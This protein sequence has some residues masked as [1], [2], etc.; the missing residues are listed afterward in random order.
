MSI[1]QGREPTEERY[2]DGNLH[3]DRLDLA[4]SHDLDTDEG[5]AAFRA[6]L[7]RA[8]RLH[9]QACAEEA[10]AGAQARRAEHTRRIRRRQARLMSDLRGELARGRQPGGRGFVSVRQRWLARGIC[11]AFLRLGAV[12]SEA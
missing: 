4:L 3:P 5:L 1:Y 8:F 12:L 2:L 7:D 10:K 6:Y 11:R 9:G